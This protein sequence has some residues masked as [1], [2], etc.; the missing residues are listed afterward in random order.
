MQIAIDGPAASGKSTAARLLAGKL[1]FLYIDTGAMYRAVTL[2][3][4]R[5]GIDFDDPEAIIGI[6]RQARIQLLPDNSGER[7][8]KVLLNEEDVTRD[9]FTPP[10]DALV[11]ITARIPA[12]RKI[13]AEAQ[14]QMASENNVVMAGRD[15]GSNVLPGAS[16]KIFLVADLLERA[17][18]RQG[19]MAINGQDESLEAIAENL[20]FRDATDSQRED[21]PLIKTPDA[22]LVD[23]SHLS[24]EE[25]VDLMEKEARRRMNP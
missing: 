11:S 5:R 16:L 18:R 22:F 6:A 3:G 23:S 20:R 25:M 10:V 7:G 19:E 24:I 2:M 14:R 13:L 21:S 17:R 1:G 8:F 4:I 12:V 9:I 15:I